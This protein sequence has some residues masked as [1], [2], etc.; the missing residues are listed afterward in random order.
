MINT[1]NTLKSIVLLTLLALIVSCFS[2][3]KTDSQIINK[4]VEQKY[5]FTKKVPNNISLTNR[6]EEL[7]LDSIKAKIIND[8]ITYFG[9]EK[10]GSAYISEDNISNDN[11]NTYEDLDNPIWVKD[12]NW[13]KWKLLFKYNSSNERMYLANNKI[14][15]KNIVL[16]IFEFNWRGDGYSM[17][18]V[19]DEELEII[20]NEKTEDHHSLNE[21]Y[22]R[23]F[24]Y[25]DKNNINFFC[26]GLSNIFEYQNNVYILQRDYDSEFKIVKIEDL[27]SYPIYTYTLPSFDCSKAKTLDEKI[28]CNNSNLSTL[29]NVLTKEYKEA[30]VFLTGN[31]SKRLRKMQLE[32]IEARKKLKG[33]KEISELYENRITYLKKE[34]ETESSKN[35]VVTQTPN[36]IVDKVNGN[37]KS[38]GYNLSANCYSNET[39]ELF[40][41]EI[42]IVIDFP[43]VYINSLNKKEGIEVNSEYTIIDTKTTS[44]MNVYKNS[45]VTYGSCGGKLSLPY[46]GTYN[47]FSLENIKTKDKAYLVY[48]VDEI[49]SYSLTFDSDME[50]SVIPYIDKGYEMRK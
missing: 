48:S 40:D 23:V 41:F 21:K 14:N 49:G 32:F 44:L 11:Y 24:P 43:K 6:Q 22:L 1:M 50:D 13:Y 37:W 9:S 17:Y 33:V 42:K 45:A 3:E 20:I 2:S 34:L 47:L 27:S 10:V 8:Y 46:H 19:T 29:D 26:W 18:L 5:D 12:V 25:I 31:N 39:D 4:E 36:Y 7:I 35:T 16:D 15:G 38:N 30:R 28:I